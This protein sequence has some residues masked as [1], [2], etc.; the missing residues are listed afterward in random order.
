MDA[1]FNSDRRNKYGYG[2]FR[3]L[4]LALFAFSVHHLSPPTA[5]NQSS[6]LPALMEYF[7]SR[8]WFLHAYVGSIGAIVNVTILDL[9][10]NLLLLSIAGMLI[11]WDVMTFDV[12]FAIIL[13]KTFG[14]DFFAGKLDT[15]EWKLVLF[16]VFAV[17]F[18]FVLYIDSD[19]TSMLYRMGRIFCV[20]FTIQ[21]VCE[22][23]DNHFEHWMF[24][25]YRYSF[26]FFNLVLLL[27][28]PLTRLELFCIQF[29]LV[30]CLFYRLS[31]F[32]V[33]LMAQAYLNRVF[34]MFLFGLHAA[35]IGTP[36]VNVVDAE[37]ATIILKESNTKGKALER[38][39][40]LPA[41][42]PIISLESVDGLVWKEM[43]DN[44]HLLLRRCP[45]VGKLT[46]IT[47]VC[48]R[49]L[50]EENVLIDADRV[51]KLSVEI[52]IE[53][54]LGMHW[55]SDFQIFVDAS[56][57]WRK[58]IAI[59]GRADESVKLRAVDLIIALI[60]ESE[61]STQDLWSLF[62]DDWRLPE[63]YSLLLQPF[64]ISPCI[65]TGK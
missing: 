23:G 22:Y 43:S 57:E 35:I 61:G 64:I 51:A 20:L 12:S 41:W 4:L 27:T 15:V 18:P 17:L 24:F 55:R 33:I 56:W 26:E 47:Q 60:K 6:F 32:C 8:R 10:F 62:K 63:Y 19:A 49:K 14:G 42:K 53:Y 9:K 45:S 30:I 31:N 48:A 21:F 39:I 7:N 38:Y 34:R 5:L 58:E 54:T 29:D 59:K 40:A 36:V 2:A 25:R 3:M 52:F 65:N 46:E 50:I 11:A 37:L 13:M 1:R 44:F 16:F 28:M